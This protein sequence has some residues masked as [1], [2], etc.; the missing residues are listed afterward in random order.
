MSEAQAGRELTVAHSGVGFVLF[1]L[2]EA[3]QPQNQWHCRCL[4]ANHQVAISRQVKSESGSVLLSK[5]VEHQVG[6]KT[7]LYMHCCQLCSRYLSCESFLCHLIDPITS[8]QRASLLGLLGFA[9]MPLRNPKRCQ[10]AVVQAAQACFPTAQDLC[11]GPGEPAASCILVFLESPV[12]PWVSFFFRGP[13]VPQHTVR[14]I[15]TTHAQSSIIE[16]HQG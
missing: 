5:C 10:A 8:A 15:N 14:P 7:R 3:G 12:I 13:T 1:G 11:T 16:M 6:L 4:A 2:W 9:G